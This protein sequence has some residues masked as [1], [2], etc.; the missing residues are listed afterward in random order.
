MDSKQR[1]KLKRLINAGFSSTA[2][3][4]RCQYCY[5]SHECENATM[6]NFQYS[7][8]HM[9]NALS[10]KRLGGVCMFNICADGET[11]IPIQVISIINALL[12][13]GHYIEVVTNGV[14][15][16]RF[17]EIAKFDRELL[18]RLTFKFSLHYLELIKTNTLNIFFDNIEKMKEAGCSFTVE[19]VPHDELVDYI[20]E[21]KQLCL[22]KVGAFCHLTIARDHANGL[23]LLSSM[24]LEEYNGIWK[25]FNSDMF[26][27]KMSTFGVK[28]KEYCYAGDWVLDVNLESGIAK[29][30]YCTRYTQNIFDNINKPI[31]FLPIGKKCELEHCYN[32][33][34]LMTLGVIPEYPCIS[35]AQVR[36]RVCEDG[37]QWLNMHM[38]DFMSQ[39]FSDNNK[40]YN[41]LEKGMKE[42]QI[43]LMRAK[44]YKS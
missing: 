13:E 9:A 37:R 15:T 30:C 26:T 39:K 4:F 11:L 31:I 8:S 17:D 6:P 3:N 36:N 22:E 34:A 42:A 12:K 24:S 5:L 2:C 18:N 10:V 16:K 38:K 21:I 1:P 35:Y 20:E 7:V 14:M 33:H 41:I 19:M 43:R 27:F 25:Q 32:S 23:K 29:Q 40:S 44:R 28:R